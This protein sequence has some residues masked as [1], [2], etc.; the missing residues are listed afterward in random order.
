MANADHATIESRGIPVGLGNLT[1]Y[2]NMGQDKA[3]PH[4]PQPVTLGTKQQSAGWFYAVG[5]ELKSASSTPQ[6]DTW[7]ICPG[8]AGYP[9]LFWVGVVNL[10]VEIPAECSAVRLF[11]DSVSGGAAQASGSSTLVSGNS[12]LV[13]GGNSTGGLPQCPATCACNALAQNGLT[14]S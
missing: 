6:W 7:L 12:T 5:G 9:K 4:G 11:A 10:L 1:L 13:S 3:N 2:M 14:T 8:D